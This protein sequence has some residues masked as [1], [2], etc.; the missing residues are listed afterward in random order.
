[1]NK[2]STDSIKYRYIIS[3]PFCIVTKC[4]MFMFNANKSVHGQIG[5]APSG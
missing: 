2:H 3:H 5:F 1:M 4:N